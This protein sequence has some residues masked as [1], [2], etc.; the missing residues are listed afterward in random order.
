M[1]HKLDLRTLLVA[2]FSIL[3]LDSSAQNFLKTHHMG[4]GHDHQYVDI[5]KSINGGYIALAVG[6]N[7]FSA[8]QISKINTAG[9]TSWVEHYSNLQLAPYNFIGLIEDSVT[10]DLTIL[11]TSHDGIQDDIFML[12]TDSVGV[13]IW[14]K[15]L[16]PNTDY[17]IPKDFK[18]TYDHGFVI[19][20]NFYD[21]FTND[22]KLLVMKTDDSGNLLWTKLHGGT[23]LAF[24]NSID[25]TSDSGFVV[26]GSRTVSGVNM[27][28]FLRLDDKG[29]TVFTKSFNHPNA[30]SYVSTS[31]VLD[32]Y[33]TY[34]MVTR[35]N[36]QLANRVR[37]IEIDQTGNVL[38]DNTTALIDSASMSI[39]SIA[40]MG[41]KI[42][43]TTEMNWGTMGHGHILE[44]DMSGQVYEFNRS[45]YLN[46]TDTSIFPRSAKAI[47]NKLILTGGFR[48]GPFFQR[49]P[50]IWSLDSLKQI[51]VQ[52]PCAN[53]LADFN[54]TTANGGD[55]VT[56]VNT[57]SGPGAGYGVY[58]DFGDGAG[59]AN[60]WNPTHIY[61]SPILYNACLQVSYQDANGTCIDSTCKTVNAD[62][63][64][65][66]NPCSSLLADFV[67]A[68]AN[69]GDTVDFASTGSGPG[70]GYGVYW[71]FGDG[72]GV[73]NDWNPTH[74]YS[75]PIL[76]NVCLQVSYQDANGT[77]ID[78]T[79]KTVNADQQCLPVSYVDNGNGNYTFIDPQ[80]CLVSTWVISNG[81]TIQG[82]DSV[83]Y[84]FTQPGIYQVCGYNCLN[85]SGCF[86]INVGQNYD[87]CTAT[88]QMTTTD[89]TNYQFLISWN[90]VD[91]DTTAGAF[92]HFGDGTYVNI[93]SDT[94]DSVFHAYYSS[95]VY[96]IQFG[97]QQFNPYTQCFNQDTIL[98]NT[99]DSCTAT[100]QI[101][102]QGSMTYDF[103]I[104]WKG[105]LVD[106][107]NPSG[108]YYIHFGDGNDT[109]VSSPTIDTISYTFA[110]AG[111]Y[112]IQFNYGQTNPFTQCTVFD[113]I[114][115][116][117]N[118]CDTILSNFS[119]SV[120]GNT[121]TF[122]NNS[123]CDPTFYAEFWDFGDGNTAQYS[124]SGS[125]FNYTYPNP[126][127]YTAC[128][129]YH[130]Q[131]PLN[132]CFDTSCVSI[133]VGQSLN[134]SVWPGDANDDGVANIVDILPI[135][136]A[137][138]S[139]G[140]VRAGASMLWVGQPA[141]DWSSNFIN[142]V[143][144][145]HA[146][147]DGDGQVALN[148]A[149]A[150][151]LNY[152]LTH[153]KGDGS[154]VKSVPLLYLE[155]S[156]DT[157]HLSSVVSIAIKLGTNNQQADSI[158]GITFDFGYENHLL[159][160][161]NMTLDFNNSWLGNIQ[162]SNDMIAI[163]TNFR[164]NALWEIGVTRTDQSHKS[165]F[166]EIA[167]VE[168]V[169]VD[170]LSGITVG[171]YEKLDLFLSD[172]HAVDQDG[173]PKNINVM[174]DSVYIGWFPNSV[175]EKKEFETLK[176]Y[177][178]PSSSDIFF[179]RTIENVTVS[180]ANNLGQIIWR[181]EN[182]TGNTLDISTLPVGLYQLTLLRDNKLEWS[183]KVIKL[184][185]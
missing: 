3:L 35:I 171:S 56:F 98:V 10:G 78:S 99:N 140:P 93:F 183:Q 87:S 16:T 114:T 72:S 148:D 5:I 138:G 32:Y 151:L 47:N 172:V 19:T 18:Q 42:L 23:D 90:G 55:T 26:A 118:F 120:S 41:T 105:V 64:N 77:C 2:L 127:T 54:W 97:Y 159:D 170:D 177:P 76:Y 83:N 144:Y 179:S 52:N 24:G 34:R 160:T 30:M 69:G 164:S 38:F 153:A 157:T 85:C 126:G 155:A 130:Y 102:A 129:V 44:L 158:H 9:D 6:T 61:S 136:L 46:P 51:V 53:L 104:D 31:G 63:P 165:G 156:V 92:L 161:N 39:N 124:C 134:D 143:N 113:T 123:Y 82:G 70:T 116:V 86:L 40:K 122:T 11:G 74:I 185:Y 60:D 27:D 106:T 8:L 184:D 108:A 180:I 89:S 147:C 43:L 96:P 75:S 58:W 117:S 182:Y 33:N 112:P 181:S 154:D 29:D 128:L 101:N 139:T 145:K 1:K 162:N 103:V 119:H 25:L 142:G 12:R 62:Q 166:G 48:Q 36:D 15:F 50:F 7:N 68:T 141:T 79:C 91:L 174:G 137:Y 173:N 57:G 149:S 163:D 109:I 21:G 80:H 94:I 125:G 71:D 22:K 176:I 49:R 146:D 178:N 67:W 131:D 135:G 100:L 132:F 13:E 175:Q 45:E 150:I 17:E 110:S 20:G 95:G 28:W 115:V 59:V 81:D 133:T 88:I 167:R 84:Q 152:G 169:T 37:L 4:V 107:V 111:T 14:H 65:N 121:V 73:A 66:P 168:I